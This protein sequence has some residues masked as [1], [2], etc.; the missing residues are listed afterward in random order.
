[1]SLKIQLVAG[2]K[3]IYE[4]PLNRDEWKTEALEEM[5]DELE[6]DLTGVL[7][8]NEIFSNRT[9]IRLLCGN[10]RR[11]DS[12]FTEFMEELDTNQ[13]IISENLHKMV[14]MDLMRRVQKKPRDIHYEPSDLGFASI[15]TCIAMRRILDEVRNNWR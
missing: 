13:K 7:E 5:L 10:I 8:I 12:R 6:T 15:L 4:L 14:A 1:M 2:K 3:V 11:I 9:R